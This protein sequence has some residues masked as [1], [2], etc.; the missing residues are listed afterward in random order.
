MHIRY[1]DHKLSTPLRALIIHR[2][3]LSF[4]AGLF[5]IF[6]PIFLYKALNENITLLAT[7]Y[8][9]SYGLYGVLAPFVMRFIVTR[10]GMRT[11]LILGTFLGAV[12]YGISAFMDHTHN[13]L[14]FF[15]ILCIASIAFRLFYWV[16]YFT[17]FAILSD[18]D[19]RARE[20]SL[21]E[22]LMSL[23][24]I[25]TPLVAAFIVSTWSFEILF[26][27]GIIVH[28]AAAI[29]I[30]LLPRIKECF[31]WTIHK[32][33]QELVARKNRAFVG[34]YI[35]EGIETSI[36]IVIWPIVVYLLLH[37]KYMDIGILSSAVIMLSIIFQ[38]FT[39]R[40]TDKLPRRNVLHI[41]SVF[42]AL[43]WIAKLF[44]TTAFHIFVADLYHRITRIFVN[45]PFEAITYDFT[46]RSGHYVD[47]YSVLREVAEQIGRSIFFIIV[48]ILTYFFT[49]NLQILFALAALAALALNALNTMRVAREDR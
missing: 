13:T 29:P 17:D 7:F 39:G 32:T 19:N 47:E 41:G 24:N 3:I 4:A 12:F 26:I 16:P 37:G 46:Q 30:F 31:T 15:T 8:L 18:A 49:I 38:L 42:Y 40:L 34:A 14:L 33:W 43:G 48:I 44:V 36:Q 2:V 21:R 25:I 20:A 23:A 27:I 9:F 28:V 35:A 45:T 10:I 1:T 6:L 22:S 5:G 11:S